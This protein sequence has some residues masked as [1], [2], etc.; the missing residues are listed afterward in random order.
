MVFFSFQGGF[1]PL[2]GS[3]ILPHGA[4]ILDP[5]KKG[6]SKK[7]RELHQGM[8]QVVKTIKSIQPDHIFLTTPHSIALS[9]DFGLYLNGRGKGN[10]E[11]KGEYTEFQVQVPFAQEL[12]SKLLDYLKKEGFPVSGVTAFAPSVN[13]PLRWG[14]AVPLWF[15]RDLSPQPSYILLSQPTRRY[16][17]PVKMIPE[18][19][20]L[21]RTLKTFFDALDKK[22]VV[23]ISA[24][25]AHTHSQNGPYQYSKQAEP[26]DELIQEWA[27]TLD[28]KILI[29]EA[30]KILQQALCCGYIGFVILQGLLEDTKV[31]P[32]VLIRANPN[33]YGMLIAKYVFGR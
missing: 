18:T 24:D 20:E 7:A 28:K 4:I 16:D 30:S 29:E 13:A 12:T 8:H 21:G 19:L 31:Q 6:I 11:W 9:H 2:V 17:Q 26:F 10:A 15:F 5:S 3:F 32:E 14:A 1:L 33:Y 25:L 27:S 22:V 23:I